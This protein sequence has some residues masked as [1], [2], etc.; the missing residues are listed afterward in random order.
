MAFVGVLARNE[1]L[2]KD[3]KKDHFAKPDVFENMIEF[4]G[5]DT[6]MPERVNSSSSLRSVSKVPEIMRNR[7]KNYYHIIL[8]FQVGQNILEI[9]VRIAKYF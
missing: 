9:F 4:L 7:F 8:Y 2:F 3:L 6:T 5:A 1:D